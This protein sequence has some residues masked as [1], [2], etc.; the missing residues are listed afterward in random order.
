MNS[1]LPSRILSLLLFL[2]LSLGLTTACGETESGSTDPLPFTDQEEGDG[3]NGEESN[4]GDQDSE[5]GS[6]GDGD[7]QEPGIRD[8]TG[9]IGP[10]DRLVYPRFPSSYDNAGNHPLLIMLHG[11][12]SN[13][14]QTLG[15][16]NLTNQAHA[17]GFVILT[18]EGTIDSMGR[19]FW[20]ATDAC[21]DFD[22]TRVDD[23]SYL[24]DLIDEA[25]EKYAVNPDQVYFMGLSN[26]GFMA[27]RMACHRGDRI[28]AIVSFN[29][30]SF[31]RPE[32]C[33]P[34][35]PVH[36]FHVHA[37][38]DT[39]VPY[40]SNLYIPGARE[41]AERWA[42]WNSCDPDP[43]GLPNVA[44]TT[45]IAGDETTVEVWENCQEGGGSELWTIHDAPHVP[46]PL[47]DFP[48][49]IID[50]FQELF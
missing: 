34:D 42:D 9:P 18:P 46:F 2:F 31:K 29:G 28:K 36:I 13:A 44:V 26:G 39:T 10:E 49:L 50:A 23:L 7:N 3:H 17:A 30:S 1:F 14:A 19:R 16:F 22:G 37:T 4:T 35:H 40:N 32:N 41:V 12:G 21:C 8:H 47:A 5:P 20:N 15:F 45:V 6:T 33:S 25:V 38:A 27:H 24:T 43:V 11:I 48:D